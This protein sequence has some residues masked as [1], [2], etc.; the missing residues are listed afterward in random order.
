LDSSVVFSE[1]YMYLQRLLST[2][3]NNQIYEI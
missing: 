3:G 1:K 2:I